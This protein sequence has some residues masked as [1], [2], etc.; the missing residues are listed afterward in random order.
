MLLSNV[1]RN[2]QLVIMTDAL[3]FRSRFRERRV[4]YEDIE[5]ITLKRDHRKPNDGSFAVLKV[6]VADRRRVVRIRVANYEH[7]Q[8]LYQ[9][10][11][12]LKSDMKK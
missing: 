7:E 10:L 9:V 1:I 3:I 11:K 2:R 8:K 5:R 12:K 6:H 4:P